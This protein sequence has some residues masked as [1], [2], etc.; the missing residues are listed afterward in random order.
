MT[1]I[2]AYAVIITAAWGALIMGIIHDGQAI[3][4]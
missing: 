3:G 2:L 1:R 4:R